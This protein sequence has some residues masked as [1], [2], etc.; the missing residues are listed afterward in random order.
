M[1]WGTF[2]PLLAEATVAAL[3]PIQERYRELMDDPAELDRVLQDG[4]DR[5]N[6]VAEATV[7]RVR[8]S[9]GFLKHG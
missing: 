9:L 1:G 4:R 7:S 3:E 8:N 6:A 5:A 2:K